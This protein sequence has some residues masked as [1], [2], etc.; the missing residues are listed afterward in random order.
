MSVKKSRRL[1][2]VINT[3]DALY[4]GVCG[5]GFPAAVRGL[6]SNLLFGK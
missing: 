3:I 2:A 1:L 5:K 4:Q 6:Q